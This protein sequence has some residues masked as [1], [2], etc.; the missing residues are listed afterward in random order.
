MMG[1]R[2]DGIMLSSAESDLSYEKKVKTAIEQIRS[3]RF[4]QIN[5]LRYYSSLSIP[6]RQ[7][8]VNRIGILGGP[9]SCLFDLPQ[10]C[11][12]SF[13]PERFVKLKPGN[14]GVK[15]ITTPIKGTIA[16]GKN[17][18]EDELNKRKLIESRKDQSELNIIVDLMRNDLNIV[19]LNGSV[20]VESPG[21]LHSFSKVHHLIAEIKGIL[22]P[23][24]SFYELIQ[25]I[26][27]GG[28]I[29]GAPKREVM[30]AIQEAEQR[31]RGFFMGNAF[32]LDDRGYFDSSILIRTL[33]KDGQKPFEYAA[34][35][36][37]VVNSC[38]EL[39]AQEI[40]SKCRVV[41]DSI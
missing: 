20:K 27:P 34:G 26:C 13:S 4:Y 8:L 5:L 22:R 6:T 41:I 30:C 25:S 24:I 23:K 3:G 17:S 10:F 9:F 15:I 11:L 32:Y 14:K 35:S 21:E 29:T 37:I 39:E 31:S 40:N 28:S 7:D 18:E 12:A 38:P 1:K 16:R 2:V 19:C 33:V 36:G